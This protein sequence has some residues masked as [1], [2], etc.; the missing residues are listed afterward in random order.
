MV[1]FHHPSKTIS[2]SGSDVFYN[3]DHTTGTYTPGAYSVE[4][5]G[6]G[7][8][9]YDTG[10]F[11][12]ITVT[13]LD[14]CDP[15]LTG[16]NVPNV[17]ILG[18]IVSPNPIPYQILDPKDSH[19][20][21]VSGSTITESETIVTCPEILFSVTT[22]DWSTSLDSI[23]SWDFATQTLEIESNDMS[24]LATLTRDL[25]ISAHYQGGASQT[26]SVSGYLDI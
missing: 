11:E 8:N 19:I 25:R 23:F 16:T 1:T 10:T 18:A 17:T 6:W 21:T 20:L 24:D 4:I 26:Y 5:R 15:D 13:I 7:D 14:P 2:V 9:S 3:G 12:T 22:P